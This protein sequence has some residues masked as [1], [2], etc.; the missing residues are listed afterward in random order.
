MTYYNQNLRNVIDFETG[1]P[2][3]IGVSN[4]STYT[5]QENRQGLQNGFRVEGDNIKPTGFPFIASDG[6]VINEETLPS[7]PRDIYFGRAPYSK[8]PPKPKEIPTDYVFYN[9]PF[10]NHQDGSAAYEVNS[11]ADRRQSALFKLQQIRSRFGTGLDQMARLQEQQ[12]LQSL[13]V[14]DPQLYATLQAENSVNALAG[15]QAQIND[16]NKTSEL[17]AY[18]N[19]FSSANPT[20][21]LKD[22]LTEAKNMITALPSLDKTDINFIEDVQRLLK[23]G[24]VLLN[25][26]GIDQAV[27]KEIEDIM[28]VLTISNA[29]PE[30]LSQV[31]NL[32]GSLDAEINALYDA[33]VSGVSV[34]PDDFNSVMEQLDD[35]VDSLDPADPDEKDAIDE[36][37]GIQQLLREA[38]QPTFTIPKKTKKIPKSSSSKPSSPKP[39]SYEDFIKAGDD[40]KL[41][42][43][44]EVKEL[45]KSGGDID[46]VLATINKNADM[47]VREQLLTLLSKSKLSAVEKDK[48]R[49]E[50]VKSMYG[51][52]SANEKEIRKSYEKIVESKNF[53]KLLTEKDLTAALL[54]KKGSAKYYDFLSILR[55]GIK[56]EY[57]NDLFNTTKDLKADQRLKVYMDFVNMIEKDAIKY[58]V[59]DALFDK[60]FDRIDKAGYL[61]TIR[62]SLENAS[63][64]KKKSLPTGR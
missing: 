40:E 7:K 61:T 49:A 53:Q 12:F 23:Q 5:Y 19:N 63:K 42:D 1:Q 16:L 50:I 32:P 58:M 62:T 26:K 45:K 28:K 35:M 36:L 18:I 25:Q 27:R 22:Y 20:E 64:S 37:K 11:E 57:V 59:S 55:G 29:L 30:E 15:L 39:P 13:L 9:T 14:N 48:V 52:L 46:K 8:A 54:D 47:D 51:S 24:E 2:V 4:D 34:D 21:V 31:P 38:K 3:I 33:I 43:A 44:N 6:I 56:H 41:L 17:N 10:M 60:R